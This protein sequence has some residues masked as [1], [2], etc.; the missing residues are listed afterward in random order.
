MYDSQPEF[1][2]HTLPTIISYAKHIHADFTWINSET[3]MAS[4]LPHAQN[5]INKGREHSH[6]YKLYAI[7]D[8]V[9]SEYDQMMLIDDD[10]LI[11]N[12][13]FNLFEMY[14]NNTFLVSQHIGLTGIPH[15]NMGVPKE[16]EEK[17]Y[18]ENIDKIQPTDNSKFLK[19]RL[20]NI[21]NSGL[22]VIDKQA[23]SVLGACFGEAI[24]DYSQFGW[25]DQGFLMEKIAK[26]K[27]AIDEIPEKLHANPCRQIEDSERFL[28][29]NRHTDFFH[30]NGLSL[31]QKNQAIENFFT[32]LQK[33]FCRPVV[34]V[35]QL[36]QD[37]SQESSIE[38]GTPKEISKKKIAIV[39]MGDPTYLGWFEDCIESTTRYCEKHGYEHI[40]CK[41]PLDQYYVSYQKPLVLRQAIEDFDYVM[42]MDAD[43]AIVND[44]ITIEQK[45]SEH[46]RWIYY[47]DDPSVWGLN[48]GV[49][50]F[51]NCSQSID[52]LEK[53][54]DLKRPNK[55]I[56]WRLDI[57]NDQGRLISI[58]GDDDLSMYKTEKFL[59]DPDDK[60]MVTQEAN[61]MVAEQALPAD[62]M[63][64]FPR[65]YNEN[66]FLLH[67]MGYLPGNVNAHI[68]Y[69]QN[70]YN[71]INVPRYWHQF[72][73][74]P[75]GTSWE[76][77]KDVKSIEKVDFETYK[78]HMKKFYFSPEY[79]DFLSE[80]DGLKPVDCLKNKIMN[81][82]INEDYNRPGPWGDPNQSKR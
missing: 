46:D 71:T 65:E 23:A 10:I 20:R 69:L 2:K 28:K 11:R 58:L 15:L 32:N 80:L 33:Y 17:M 29:L 27:I 61:D 16:D 42:W 81:M 12:N 24:E 82:P 34:H 43:T 36:S 41:K 59:A 37:N 52:L 64:T 51:K 75:S 3:Q 21:F 18:L 13:A 22:Y 30:F 68:K 7:L 67:F 49:L 57:P 6:F 54:W 5:V 48:S 50:I 62:F 74:I 78:S 72:K 40:L 31:D 73:Q 26:C 38:T 14:R 47:C 19:T 66:A 63:N 60:A 1:L 44:E 4:K 9:Y 55:D 56:G 8:F 25:Y 45:I 76:I 79:V 77:P 70:K 39:Q 35:G 53:W